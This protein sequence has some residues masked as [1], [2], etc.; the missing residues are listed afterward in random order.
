MNICTS[1]SIAVTAIGAFA[2][3][4]QPVLADPQGNGAEVSI[5][6]NS[7][8][9]AVPTRDGRIIAANVFTGAERRV[10][11]IS[12]PSG[13]DFLICTFDVPDRLVPSEK[14][15]AKGFGCKVGANGERT[16]DTQMLVTPGGKGLLTCKSN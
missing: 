6:A 1:R 12:T 16:T 9:G 10:Q 11:R 5:D 2:L 3:S 4:T 8:T 7:C 13:N 15:S 14:R